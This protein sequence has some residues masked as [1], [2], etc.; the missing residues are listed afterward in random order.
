MLFIRYIFVFIMFLGKITTNKIISISPGGFKGFY[1]LGTLTYMKEN[2]D[3]SKYVFSG[4]SAGAWC[5]LIMCMKN[6][7]NLNSF[8]D[9]DIIKSKSIF[10]MEKNIKK[11]LLK[12]YDSSDFDLSRIHIGVTCINNFNIET[13][14]YS[15]FK[16][17]ED[18]INCCIASSHIPFITGGL[19][20]K[21]N[22]KLTFDGGF[23][24][25]PYLNNIKS[26]IHIHPEI[27]NKDNVSELP[28]YNTTLFN[29]KSYN[30]YQLYEDGYNDAIKNKKYLDKIMK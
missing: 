13:N 1:Q 25:N 30:F 19:F 24:D 18:T 22:N 9:E 17:L 2:Y 20:N 5:S 11:K 16:N 6:K 12:K 15:N 26:V 10:D 4:A 28:F 8:L 23:S 21:Y 27:W 7:F 29:R 3:L 14:I